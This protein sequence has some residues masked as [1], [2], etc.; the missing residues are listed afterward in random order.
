MSRFV[1]AGTEADSVPR[2]D[3]WIQAQKEVEAQRQSKP[4]IKPGEQEG[5]KSLYEVLQQNK[6]R[7]YAPKS[8]WRRELALTHD[9]SHIPQPQSK[10]HSKNKPV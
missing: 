10:M 6:G 9:E 7:C 8:L 4:V 2:D 5:G 3:A 1:S